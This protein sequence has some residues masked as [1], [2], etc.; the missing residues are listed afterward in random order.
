M[1]RDG[2]LPIEALTQ[3]ERWQLVAELHRTGWTDQDIAGHTRATEYTIA[4]IRTA[5]GLKPNLRGG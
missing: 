2:S 4:R 5:M 1:A 3:D